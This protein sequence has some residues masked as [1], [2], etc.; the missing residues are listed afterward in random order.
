MN[1]ELKQADVKAYCRL[2]DLEYKPELIDELSDELKQAIL[3]CRYGSSIPINDVCPFK[4]YYIFAK[5]KF[6][7][8][9]KRELEENRKIEMDENHE[10]VR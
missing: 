10:S 1:R 2:M 6:E 8:F 9:A 7:L 5:N 3:R 4:T